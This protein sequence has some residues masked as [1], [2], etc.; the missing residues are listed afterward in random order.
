MLN[1]KKEIEMEVKSKFGSVVLFSWWNHSVKEPMCRKCNHSLNMRQN[2]RRSES[3]RLS[4]SLKPGLKSKSVTCLE[5]YWH[6]YR[7]PGEVC[8]EA[9]SGSK[10]GKPA[11]RSRA[12]YPEGTVWPR[13]VR[14][15]QCSSANWGL[16]WKVRMEVLNWLNQF[17]NDEPGYN[18]V[19]RAA[20]MEI[21][22]QVVVPGVS[23]QK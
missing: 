10:P 21:L 5:H 19:W 17:S 16:S 11:A 1:W 20:S 18:E 13:W 23:S 12:L 15:I 9:G 7:E 8:S 4:K 6:M 3:K 14:T 22:T 2:S